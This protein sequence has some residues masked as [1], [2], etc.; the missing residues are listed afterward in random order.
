[1]LATRLSMAGLRGAGVV[2]ASALLAALMPS[3][4]R[5]QAADQGQAADTTASAQP[6]TSATLDY[7]REIFRFPAVQRDPFAPVRAGEELGPRFEDLELSGVI[8]NERLGSVA[9]LVDRT[10]GKRY[11]AHQGE[12]VG[13]AR[14]QSIRPGEVAF[15]VSGFGQ[16]RTE[17][18]KVKKQDK[19]TSG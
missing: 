8:Y 11:R 1:M 7:R 12:R 17:V 16:S 10:T 6:A 19:E 5:A 3:G 4:A 2:A 13:Q 9:V 14:V 15:V 18:L